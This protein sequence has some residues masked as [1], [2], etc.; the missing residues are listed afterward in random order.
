M[1]S[2]C[3]FSPH[4]RGLRADPFTSSWHLSG[5]ELCPP[6]L[7]TLTVGPRTA[8]HPHEPRVFSSPRPSHPPVP[9]SP[10]PPLPA[11]P[12]SCQP[13]PSFSLGQMCSIYHHDRK[14][15]M[16]EWMIHLSSEYLQLHLIPTT[17]NTINCA[18]QNLELF[19]HFSL[20]SPPSQGTNYLHVPPATSLESGPLSCCRGL[21]LSSEPVSVPLADQLFQSCS[22]LAGLVSPNLFSTL[23]Q[24]FLFKNADV[25]LMCSTG[26]TI[27]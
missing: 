16:P 18:T 13:G 1:T 27:F 25:T 17:G 4:S 14:L 20:F 22:T 3:G 8:V 9:A 19:P 12:L 24:D 2:Q 5:P 6:R 26:A 10:N 11:G 23:W 15:C 21:C 7:D